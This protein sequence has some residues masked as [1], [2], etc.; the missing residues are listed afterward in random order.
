MPLVIP[1][2]FSNVQLTIQNTGAGASANSSIA[3][4][5]ERTTHLDQAAVADL[6]NRFR[7]ALAPIVDT[8]WL[9]GPTH[10]N[11]TWDDVLYSW[12]DTGTEAGTHSSASY[13]SPA[14]AYVVSK[15]TGIA[16]R[17]FR[18]RCFMPGVS[19][20]DVDESGTLAGAAVNLV[21]AAFEDLRSDL[22][23]A[24]S[25]VDVVLFHDSETPGSV[26]PTSIVAFACRT[27]VGTMRPRQRR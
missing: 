5:I 9:L 27:V 2:G 26:V 23:A 24:A 13:T 3:V 22:L 4:G 16:G 25:L 20:A 19:E 7:D 15:Q 6:A 11:E 17:K 18:G 12:D 21:T 10:I 14:I 1:N 8:A